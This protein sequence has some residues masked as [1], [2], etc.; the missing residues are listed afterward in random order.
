MKKLAIVSDNPF[1]VESIKVMLGRRSD[2]AA[3]F[4]YSV[5]NKG[6]GKLIELGSQ[7]IDVKKEYSKLTSSYDL[8]LSLHCKQIFPAALINS[9]PCYNLHPGFNPHNRGWFPQVFSIINKLPAG[10]TLHKMDEQI[11]H[12]EIIDQEPV[13]IDA[14]DTSLDVYDKIM[15][16]ELKILDRSFDKLISGNYKPIIPAEGNYNSIGDYRKLQKLDLDATMRVGEVIDL[17]RALSH[18]PYKN[19][20][21]IDPVSGEKVFVEVRFEKES[22]EGK[23]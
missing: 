7:P 19:A 10:A 3:D 6:P 1:L 9:L 8:V 11:D 21:F 17:L 14:C 20:W 5:I 22:G 13:A 16:A 23:R 15:L 18:P 12:G 2:C 4:F